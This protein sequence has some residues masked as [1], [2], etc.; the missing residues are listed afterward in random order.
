LPLKRIADLIPIPQNAILVRADSGITSIKQLKGKKIAYSNSGA[1][2]ATLKKMLLQNG[3]YLD[4]VELIDV[5]YNLLQ[6]LLSGKVD[7][8][9]GI[10]RNFE[11]FELQ[12]HGITPRLFLPEKNGVPPYSALILVARDKF[13]HSATCMS[14][15]RALT[16]ATAYLKKHPDESWQAFVTEYPY[17]NDFLNKHAFEATIPLFAED[18]KTCH[19]KEYEEYAKFLHDYMLIETTPKARSYMSCPGQFPADEDTNED[20]EEPK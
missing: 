10:S 6:P 14:F 3:L 8:I 12:L 5:H 18:P 2:N 20:E 7:A 16:Q 17:L 19:I 15:L 9:I 13:A 11:P 4:N 1:A